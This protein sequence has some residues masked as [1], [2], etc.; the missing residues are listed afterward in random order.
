MHFHQIHGTYP[1]TAFILCNNRENFNF[2]SAKLEKKIAEI[3]FN[4]GPKLTLRYGGYDYVRHSVEG[5]ATYWRCSLRKSGCRAFISSR[6]VD[7]YIMVS[8]SK[9]GI[10]HT[11]HDIPSIQRPKQQINT[12]NQ[13]IIQLTIDYDQTRSPLGQPLSKQNTQQTP[14]IKYTNANKYS[15]DS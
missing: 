6:Y 8:K 14:Q 15:N 13:T 5:N 9:D 4:K 3:I 11:D 7:S 10:I 2:I 1:S 12:T